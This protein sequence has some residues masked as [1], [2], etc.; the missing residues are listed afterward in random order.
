M[1]GLEPGLEKPSSFCGDGGET[2]TLKLKIVNKITLFVRLYVF[3]ASKVGYGRVHAN[4]RL[5]PSK[6]KGHRSQSNHLTSGAPPSLPPRAFAAPALSAATTTCRPRPRASAA[7][8]RPR[9]RPGGR[10]RPARRPRQP[11]EAEEE[12]GEKGLGHR[13]RLSNRR[14]RGNENTV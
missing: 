4:T 1:T 14:L 12:E 8:R 13:P 2:R 6:R 5:F 10:R 9:R 11:G 3:F 7:S